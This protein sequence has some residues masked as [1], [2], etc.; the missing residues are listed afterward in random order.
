PTEQCRD[1]FLCAFHSLGMGFSGSIPEWGT[2]HAGVIGRLAAPRPAPESCRD[3]ALA[4]GE[5]GT[6][7]DN[8]PPALAEGA[9]PR[10][11]LEALRRRWFRAVSVGLVLAVLAGGLVRVL[12][13]KESARRN[14]SWCHGKARILVIALQRGEENDGTRSVRTCC[15]PGAGG[16]AGRGAPGSGGHPCGAHPDHGARPD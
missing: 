6:R 8:L 13:P 1:C 15:R 5:W 4:A 3:A 2:P 11:L 16:Q 12:R 7:P 9:S 14:R 10:T